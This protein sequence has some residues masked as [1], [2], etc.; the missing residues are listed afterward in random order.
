MTR[1]KIAATL[2]SLA[3]L[4]ACGG[5]H[6]QMMVNNQDLPEAV[7]APMGQAQAMSTSATGELTYECREKKD[8]AGAFEW[9]FV[10]PVATL[11]N[12]AG[13]KV[14]SYYAGPTWESLDGSKVTGKQV[15]VAPGAAGAIPLQLVK[16]NP[17]MGQGTMMG[18]SYIQRL[19]TKGG[20]APVLP[21]GMGEKGQRQ[22]VAY[23]ADYVFYKPAM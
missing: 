1:F 11:R 23:S 9:G 16:A 20:V 4:T 15:A 8:M 19:N 6:G 13:E 5:M 7:R 17:A 3:S 14:G 21:C 22:T 10:G 18:I 2:L 12:H